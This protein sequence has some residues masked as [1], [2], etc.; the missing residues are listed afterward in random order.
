MLSFKKVFNRILAVACVPAI[1]VCGIPLTASAETAVPV[2][3]GN[4]V[5][6]TE[7]KTVEHLQLRKGDGT[8]GQIYHPGGFTSPVRSFDA[9]GAG[10]AN[11]HHIY[12]C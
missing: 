8:E 9:D 12:A 2:N 4:S 7:A 5:D 6:A 1:L 3:D 10:W 11:N